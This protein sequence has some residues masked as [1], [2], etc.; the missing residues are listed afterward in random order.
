[1]VTVDV[2]LHQERAERDLPQP[3]LVIGGKDIT[4]TSGGLYEHRNPATGLIQ[5]YIPLAGPSEVD[6]AV[7]A[8]RQAFEVC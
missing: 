6:Q 8:A 5:A 2:E 1:M 3:R 7:A 4:D